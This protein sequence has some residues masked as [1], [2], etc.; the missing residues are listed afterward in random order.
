MAEADIEALRLRAVEAAGRRLGTE[1][2]AESDKAK[3]GLFASDAGVRLCAMPSKHYPDR[4][5][6]GQ[7][8]WWTLRQKRRDFLAARA[9]DAHLVLACEGLHH[10]YLFDWLE[11]ASWAGEPKKRGH[12]IFIAE[13]FKGH[14]GWHMHFGRADTAYIRLKPYELPLGNGNGGPPLDDETG[15]DGARASPKVPA[16]AEP[17]PEPWRSGAGRGPRPEA[18][19]YSGTYDPNKPAFTYLLRFAKTNIWKV[20]WAHHVQARC[21]DINTHIPRELLERVLGKDPIWQVYTEQECSTAQHAFDLEQA[22]LRVLRG[23]GFATQG[24]RAECSVSDMMQIWN[25]QLRKHLS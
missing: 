12:D 7:E 4:K 18:R 17:S 9:A 22:I 11:F 20:G 6:K 19:G 5:R 15:E 23:K 1:F 13:N 8:Y 14:R 24:E 2:R 21:K 16:F 3:E 10:A 25:E